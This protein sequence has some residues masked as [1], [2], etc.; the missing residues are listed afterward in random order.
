M[1]IWLQ[2]DITCIWIKLN[3]IQLKLN[4]NTHKEFFAS[5]FKGFTNNS[6]HIHRPHAPVQ[7]ES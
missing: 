5:N 4:K 7:G 6:K 1:T 3:L 2:A